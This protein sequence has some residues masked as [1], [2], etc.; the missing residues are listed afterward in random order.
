MNKT[1][2]EWADMTWN[3]VTGCR[4]ECDYCYARRIA[5]RFS[6]ADQC[7]TFMGGSPYIHVLSNGESIEIH[8]L[9]EP[10]TIELDKRGKPFPFGFS[11]TLH[12]YRLEEPQ[13]RKKPKTIFVCSMA[14]L[15]GAWVPDKW[16]EKVFK[17]CK[18]APQHR[19]LFLT[20]NPVRYLE[21]D[22]A[23]LLPHAD[24][25]WYGSTV[26][27][28]NAKAMYVNPNAANKLKA[29]WSMEPLLERVNVSKC[30]GIVNWIILG[31]MTGPGSAQ[32]QPKREWIEEI[33]KAADGASIPVFMKDSLIPIIGEEN[34]RRDF[35]WG[36]A[37][38]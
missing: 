29:F 32:R 18:E 9:E 23:A 10:A 16:I 8:E 22:K 6:T 27:D 15:F 26:A 30:L 21:L 7:H 38:D 4:H 20:K 33:V 1:D 2:I 36:A 14:D 13:H 25:F 3:P 19:Y 28:T 35:P 24:N 11:P 17:A 31:A 37:N 34:M 12:E 5:E